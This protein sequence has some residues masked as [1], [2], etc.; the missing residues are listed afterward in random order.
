M[1]VRALPRVIVRFA[2]QSSVVWRAWIGIERDRIVG[3]DSSRA[4]LLPP[5]LH[6]DA[7]VLSHFDQVGL[8][9]RHMTSRGQ[10]AIAQL[11]GGHAALLRQRLP[12]F[13]RKALHARL[14]GDAA[15][16]AKQL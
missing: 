14:N 1:I 11:I 3:P 9:E 2:P 8:D 10:Q 7:I 6:G 15:R 12:S 4:H 16:T 5:A 13:G